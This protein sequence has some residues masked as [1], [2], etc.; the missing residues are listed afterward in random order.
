MGTKLSGGQ[1]QRVA[2]ARAF[3]KNTPILILDEAT[4]SLDTKAELAVQDA[5]NKLM[6]GKTTVVVAHR[7]TSIKNCDKIV[8]IKDG[9]IVETGTHD[10]LIDANGEYTM[11]YKMQVLE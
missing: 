3:L 2:I 9:S 11:L 4:S 7:L 5:L 8:V 10:E 6:K 1:K